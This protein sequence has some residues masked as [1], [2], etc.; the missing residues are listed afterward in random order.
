MHP[1]IRL[2]AAFAFLAALAL[3]APAQ[4]APPPGG[5]APPA[6]PPVSEFLGKEFKEFDV[7]KD[8]LQGPVSDPRNLKGRVVLVT[9]LQITDGNCEAFS[10]PHA[11]ELY[12]KYKDKGLTVVGIW[13]ILSDEGRQKPE[14][15]QAWLQMMQLPFPVAK[16]RGHATIEHYP[17]IGKY[18]TP[19]TIVID[20]EGV[21][22]YHEMGYEPPQKQAV[23]DCVEKYIG[24]DPDETAASKA[25]TKSVELGLKAQEQG[26]FAA[27]YA[28]LKRAQEVIEGKRAEVAPELAEKVTLAIAQI[29]AQ[30]QVALDAAAAL[31]EAKKFPEAEAAFK[32]VVATFA[33]T[34]SAKE[35]TDK[36]AALGKDPEANAAIDTAKQMV[37]AADLWKQAE[38][39]EKAK[40]YGKALE[41]FRRIVKTC[42]KAPQAA[43]AQKRV[44]ILEK[45]PV[46][47][48][49]IKEDEVRVECEKWIRN[50]DNFLKDKL[51][52]KA[53]A[54]YRRVIE[55]YPNSPLN[56]TARQKISE[57]EKKK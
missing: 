10:L 27:A 34:P 23:A 17:I 28:A 3:P 37:E 12:T 21:I 57:A 49:A 44:E 4:D 52:D 8:W 29:E 40:S 47:Q 50:G 24:Q 32:E 31:F 19:M 14:M 45:D 6:A 56:E 16:D 30:A 11:K 7:E 25:V 2:L 39:A 54:E 20:R 13:S 18:T 1:P 5:E 48:E 35:A 51:Y 42:A 38:A 55:Q 9:F 36:L 33:G 41:L 46:V 22:R 53:I 43:E 15:A 26:D